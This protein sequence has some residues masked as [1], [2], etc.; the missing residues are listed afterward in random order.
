[1]TIAQKLNVM[2]AERLR[3]PEQNLW[4]SVVLQAIHDAFSKN[5]FLRWRAWAW[6]YNNSNDYR[7]VC[8]M[9]GISAD[10]L[11]QKMIETIFYNNL[12]Q[13]GGFFM[14]EFAVKTIKTEQVESKL[15]EIERDL[16]RVHK[17]LT[18]QFDIARRAKA[19]LHAIYDQ[20][21]LDKAIGRLTFQDILNICK[22]SE[23]EIDAEL[24]D[25]D[26]LEDDND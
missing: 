25:D 8:D 19:I 21:E 9:A 2:P 16:K 5:K 14:N 22:Q 23:F 11:R 24:E 13:K 1:M 3:M 18:K 17:S 12:I 10:Q 6:F 20:Q 7:H 15:F 4:K 26:E